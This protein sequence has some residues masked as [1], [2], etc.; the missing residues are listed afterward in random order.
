LSELRDKGATTIL[1]YRTREFK[2]YFFQHPKQLNTLLSWNRVYELPLRQ[3]G[4]RIMAEDEDDFSGKSD[5]KE[6]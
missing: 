1:L 6:K 4:A 2:A 5:I 3:L